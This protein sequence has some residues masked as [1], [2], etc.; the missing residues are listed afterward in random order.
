MIK[1]SLNIDEPEKIALEEIKRE[2]GAPMWY[3]IKV[4][5]ESKSDSFLTILKDRW[6]VD[7]KIRSANWGS[8]AGQTFKE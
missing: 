3:I 4:L 5:L 1:K 2:T 7:W 6:K 8:N